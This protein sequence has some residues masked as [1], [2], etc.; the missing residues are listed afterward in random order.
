MF[1]QLAIITSAIIA[2]WCALHLLVLIISWLKSVMIAKTPE[3]FFIDLR[4]VKDKTGQQIILSAIKAN[5]K[6]AVWFGHMW[7]VWPEAPPLAHDGAKE[8]GYYAYCKIAALRGLIF[9]ILSPFALFFGQKPIN[10]IMK[11]DAG[12]NRDWQLIV[13]IDDEDYNRAIEIDNAWRKENRYAMRPGIGGRT[14]TCRD[15][16]FDIASVIGLKP[17]KRNWAQFPPET[18]MNF[19]ENNGIKQN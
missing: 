3:P 5:P 2:I 6:N 16:V 4:K 15:Y 8:A 7:V 13:Q 14:Y 10:G 12:T 18:F 1:L 11:D 17:N 19:L 9:S